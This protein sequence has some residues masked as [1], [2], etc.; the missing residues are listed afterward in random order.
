[1]GCQLGRRGAARQDRG[2][3]DVSRSQ[4]LS[5]YDAAGE[6]AKAIPMLEASEHDSPRLQ[7]LPPSLAS[8]FLQLKRYDDALAANDRAR[9]RR[10]TAPRRLRVLSVR[11]NIFAAQGDAPAAKKTLEEARR[12]RAGPSGRSALRRRDRYR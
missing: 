1:M 9:W 6:I 12:L 3:A 7:P 2:A 11:A 8:V 5:A 10:S 4:P